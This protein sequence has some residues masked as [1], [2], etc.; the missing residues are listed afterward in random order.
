MRQTMN[1]LKTSINLTRTAILAAVNGLAV[2]TYIATFFTAGISAGAAAAAT[3]LAVAVDIF[4]G[5]IGGICMA[6]EAILDPIVMTMYK[7]GGE[8]PGG[9]RPFSDMLSPQAIAILS[10]FIPLIPFLTIFDPYVCWGT[11][12]NGIANVRMRI[13]P[14]MPAFMSDRSLSLVYHAAWQSGQSTNLPAGTILT[15]ELDPLPAGYKWIADSDLANSPNTNE[16]VKIAIASAEAARGSRKNL[17]TSGNSGTSGSDKLPSYIAVQ[18]CEGNTTPSEDGKSCL[19]SVQKTAIALPIVTVQCPTGSYDDG[20]NCW[21]TTL[22]TNCSGGQFVYR[23]TQTW[24]D[25]TGYY[26]V[27]STAPTCSDGTRP[28]ITTSY[29]DRITCPA[30]YEKNTST[31]TA[32]GAIAATDVLCYQRCPM[33]YTREGALCLGSTPT[34][35][36]NYMFGSTTLYREQA[37]NTNLLTDITQVTFPYC[38][39]GSQV[40]LDRMGQFYYNNSLLN[41]T[42]NEDGTVTVELIDTFYGVIA[43]SELSCDVACSITF[44]TYN[45]VT[46]G[47]YTYTRG[48]AAAYKDDPIFRDCPFCYR[49]FYFI[50]GSNDVQGQF[51]VSGCTFADYTAVEAMAQST[52]DAT[53]FLVSLPKK[54]S[55]L[56]KE[57]VDIRDMAAFNAAWKNGQIMSQAGGGLLE[58]GISIA[59]G[60]LG[61]G[62][63][64]GVASAAARSAVIKGASSIALKNLPVEQAATVSASIVKSIQKA[65]ISSAGDVAVIDDAAM[66]AA[67]ASGL[68]DV[69]ARTVVSETM[70]NMQ[71]PIADAVA[72][73]GGGIVGGTGAGLFSS[74]YLAPIIDKAIAAAISPDILDN[75]LTSTIVGTNYTNLQVAVNQNWWVANLG[76]IY[77]MAPGYHPNINFCEKTKISTGHC[78]NKY[79]IRD[80]VN[81]YHNTHFNF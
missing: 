10:A 37:L 61:V 11:D 15:A 28:T 31:T 46:G 24:N 65:T 56:N 66:A 49:R 30:G 60:M 4:F 32:G 2:G 18:M 74:M 55:V 75:V 70:R 47:G 8:C 48:C 5:I 67:K 12:S 80:M 6:I 79:I 58:A 69:A 36:R 44:V 19:Q 16:I 7:T 71:W 40:M 81:K 51:T 63:G 39:F 13:P 17:V 3:T 57:N 72:N 53:N 27:S 35:A 76:P 41:P 73:I 34:T 23:T 77:E 14:K 68:D 38:D 21:S 64:M 29:K 22:S 25:T 9:Y 20:F 33:N 78:T 62:L 43:S 59:G 54:W 45:P 52:D 1:N 26:A 50:R 42:I